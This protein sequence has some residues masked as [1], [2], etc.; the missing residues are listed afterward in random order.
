M[1]YMKIYGGADACQM[2]YKMVCEKSC[3]CQVQNILCYAAACVW[4]VG[5]CDI[6]HFISLHLRSY[7]YHY[8]TH[9]ISRFAPLFRP[10]SHLDAVVVVFGVFSCNCSSNYRLFCVRACVAHHLK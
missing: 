4:A 9:G 2:L 7:T 1:T 10:F 3:E 5:W 6:F 8:F